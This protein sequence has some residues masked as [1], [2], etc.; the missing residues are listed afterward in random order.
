[1][2][3]TTSEGQAT[4]STTE[5]SIAFNAAAATSNN[6]S[7]PGVYQVFIDFSAL[8]SAEYYEVIIYESAMAGTNGGTVLSTIIYQPSDPI[9]V[10][11]AL[12][13]VNKWD[14]TITKVTGTDRS[15][16]WSIRKVG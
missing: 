6:M 16:N 4:I 12:T 13:L 14:M 7:T 2:S 9:W 8:T 11:P 10:S 15:I 5:W 1:M 3:I